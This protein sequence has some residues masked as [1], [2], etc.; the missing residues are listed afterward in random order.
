M[1]V[2][3]RIRFEVFKRDRFTCAYCGKHPPDVLL[4]VDHVIPRA[5]GGSDDIENLVT[6]C[7][8]CNNGKSD[9][10]LDEGSRPRVSARTVAALEERLAQAKAYME[11]QGQLSTVADAMVNRLV[12]MWAKAFGARDVEED[13]KRYWRLEGGG[14]WPKEATLREFLRELDIEQ[15]GYA[16]DVAANRIGDAHGNERYFYAVCWRMIRD[17]QAA[18]NPATDEALS[19]LRDENAALRLENGRLHER[20]GDAEDTIRDLKI[21]VRRLREEAG[22]E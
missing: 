13:G 8:E 11:L 18:A 20:L 12:E 3:T 4:E 16:I 6:A 9:R 7:W 19:A 15:I 10:L 5:A 1:S 14:S 2:S 22:R 21:N 17:R